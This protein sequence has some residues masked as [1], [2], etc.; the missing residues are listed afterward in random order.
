MPTA[1]EGN[2]P[3]AR[4]GRSFRF[5]QSPPCAAVDF[6]VAVRVPKLAQAAE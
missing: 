1:V 5:D 6:D 2:G 3:G 4:V